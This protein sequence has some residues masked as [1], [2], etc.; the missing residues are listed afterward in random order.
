MA[1]K[2]TKAAAAKKAEES[3]EPVEHEHG[4]YSQYVVEG[5]EPD[6]DAPEQNAKVVSE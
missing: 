4:D 3:T 2:T 1:A 5:A 6:F